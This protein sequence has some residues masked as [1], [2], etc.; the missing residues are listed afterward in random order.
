MKNLKVLIVALVTLLFSG[1]YDRDIVDFKEFDHALPKVENLNYTKQGDVIQLTWQ[2]PATVSDDFRRPLEVSIQ[3]VENNI[4]R[5]KIIVGNGS[6]FAD[7]PTTAGK[8][9][10]FVVKLLGYLTEEAREEGKTD[11]VFSEGQVIETD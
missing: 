6:T 10:R 3:V 9:Y 5:Q 2:I 8:K 11:K 7:I 4:Y 1:C